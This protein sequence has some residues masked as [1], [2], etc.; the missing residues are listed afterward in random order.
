MIDRS[1]VTELKQEF[2]EDG[3]GDLVGLFLDDVQQGLDDLCVAAPDQLE[4]QFHCLKGSA[5][6]MGMSELAKHCQRAEFAAR[7]G[8]L[9]NE[10]AQTA[11]LF[12]QAKKALL[13]L[14]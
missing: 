9:T 10:V 14:R 2:G 11:C 13:Q 7:S 3:F 6:N 12:S 5:L 8:R 4:A 1:R